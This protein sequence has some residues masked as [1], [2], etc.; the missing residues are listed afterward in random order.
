M[1]WIQREVTSRGWMTDK[2]FFPGMA[3]VRVIKE[4]GLAASASEAGR[5]IEQRAVR[6]EQQKVEDRALVLLPGQRYLLQVGAR[7]FAYVDLKLIA[8]G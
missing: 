2:E 6:V 1:P 3:L 5:L 7:R 8:G 4:A